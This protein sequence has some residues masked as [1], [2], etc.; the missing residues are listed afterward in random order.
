MLGLGLLIGFFSVISSRNLTIFGYKSLDKYNYP[1]HDYSQHSRMKTDLVVTFRI[2]SLGLF[3]HV[4]IVLIITSFLAIR[5]TLQGYSKKW[6]YLEIDIAIEKLLFQ[7]VVAL[8]Q[9]SIVITHFRLILWHQAEFCL[10]RKWSWKCNYDPKICFSLINMI[11]KLVS[12]CVVYGG[13]FFFLFRK[14]RVIRW[15]VKVANSSLVATFRICS[16]RP[17]FAYCNCFTYYLVPSISRN[18]AGLLLNA[19]FNQFIRFINLI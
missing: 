16:P 19:Q 3:L 4:A 12:L 18:I 2:F 8:N 17:I 11:Q 15:L 1:L 9:I 5:E 6:N 14:N 7:C 10:E 13:W